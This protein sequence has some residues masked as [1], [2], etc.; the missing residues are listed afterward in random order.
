MGIGFR[1][2]GHRRLMG[3]P[4][5]TQEQHAFIES[6]GE[7]SNGFTQH[8]GTLE[9][10]QRRGDT[11]DE[12]RQNW[13]LIQPAEQELQWLGEPVVH[14]HTVRNGKIDPAL[15][16]GMRTGLRQ[17]HRHGQLSCRTAEITNC[18]RPNA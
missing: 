5:G 13:H 1:Q 9:T 15:H 10:G 14:L 8:A 6:A 4:T 18:R 3:K 7:T 12:H 17:L 16:D 2:F 11:V